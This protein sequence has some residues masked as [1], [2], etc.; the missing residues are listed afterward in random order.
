MAT[1]WILL[2]LY[3]H[4]KSNVF[5]HLNYLYPPLWL[6]SFIIEVMN[7]FYLFARE[8]SRVAFLFKGKELSNKD[9]IHFNSIEYCK[10][11]DSFLR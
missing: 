4:Q 8:E 5:M 2:H 6:D 10:L 7:E 11:L 9:E 3:H 1:N